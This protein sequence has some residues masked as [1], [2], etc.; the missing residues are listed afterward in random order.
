MQG[1]GSRNGSNPRE[2]LR[3]EQYVIQILHLFFLNISVHVT[4]R[5]CMLTFQ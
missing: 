3:K 1:I 4:V 5:N 2:P